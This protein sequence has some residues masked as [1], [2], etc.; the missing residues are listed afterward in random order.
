MRNRWL[1]GGLVVS[2]VLN[3]LLVGFLAGRM[4]PG[5]G[6]VAVRPDPTI[7]IY[8]MIGFLPEARRDEVKSMLR[9]E[10]RQRFPEIRQIR[11]S[12]RLIREAV[13]ADP[14]VRGDLEE[15]LASLRRQLGATQVAAHASFV[16]IVGKLTPEERDRLAEAMQR[17]QRDFNR[18]RRERHHVD[19]HR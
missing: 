19:D 13:T 18:L 14:F 15:A 4:A 1:I 9:G 7:G 5:A 3:L 2:I 10:A 17:P 12:H 11:G 8:R 16:D 6:F